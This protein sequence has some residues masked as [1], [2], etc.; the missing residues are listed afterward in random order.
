[1]ADYNPS[2]YSDDRDFLHT[3]DGA[4]RTF[5]P[6]FPGVAAADFLAFV[7]P[8]GGDRAPAAIESV[9]FD[10]PDNLPSLATVTLTAAPAAEA[11][12]QITLGGMNPTRDV[13]FAQSITGGKIDRS[14][15]ISRLWAA[16]AAVERHGAA[17]AFSGGA[18]DQTAR[19]EAAAAQTRA[20]EAEAVADEAQE[21]ADDAAV[22]AADA[23]RRADT[24]SENAQRALAATQTLVSDAPLPAELAD[25]LPADAA[26]RKTAPS[27]RAVFARVKTLAAGIAANVTDIAL[28]AAAIR[29]LQTMGGRLQSH[30]SGAGLARG[31]AGKAHCGGGDLHCADY[32]FTSRHAGRRGGD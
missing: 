30:A 12:I 27:I 14:V 17:T 8:D 24:A 31:P 16:V 1:M 4:N 23:G 19:D 11:K 32:Q 26:Q 5:R 18:H 28:N 6:D 15:D 7:T 25:N 20:N 9:A 10:E 29:V 3:G 13:E 22:D 21:T 2:N